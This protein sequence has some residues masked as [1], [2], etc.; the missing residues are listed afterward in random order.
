M[1]TDEFNRALC[2]TCPVKNHSSP[3]GAVFLGIYAVRTELT[4]QKRI[5]MFLLAVCLVIVPAVA[6]DSYLI[7]NQELAR[8]N[9]SNVISIFVV[10]TA[11]V[12]AIGITFSFLFL[13]SRRQEI[14]NNH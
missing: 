5:I 1:D 2:D 9:S 10:I 12:L 3:M 7:M 13:V 6:V 14:K 8:Y 4:A 11:F